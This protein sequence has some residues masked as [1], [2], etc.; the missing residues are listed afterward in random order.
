MWS[1]ARR[2]TLRN[3]FFFSFFLI[4]R[5]YCMRIGSCNSDVVTDLR[6]QGSGLLDAV[7][8]DLAGDEHG[9]PGAS[10]CLLVFFFETPP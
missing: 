2:G 3:L 10:S 1:H 9:V 5:A 8:K 6:L 7:T 4:V